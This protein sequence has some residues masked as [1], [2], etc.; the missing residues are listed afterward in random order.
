M[1]RHKMNGAIGLCGLMVDA[2]LESMAESV[3]CKVQV[4][5]NISS[6]VVGVKCRSGCIKCIEVEWCVH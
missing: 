6:S 5:N 1:I 2:K 3:Y 4:Y